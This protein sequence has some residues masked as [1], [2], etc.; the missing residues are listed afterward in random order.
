MLTARAASLRLLLALLGF[1]IMAAGVVLAIEWQRGSARAIAEATRTLEDRA[2]DVA[3]HIQRDVL[4]RLRAVRAWV[5]L[6]VAQELAVDDVDKR[7]SATL[8]ELARDLGASDLAVALDS[9]G[10]IVS[11]SDSSLI[12]RQAATLLP[13]LD[14]LRSSSVMRDARGAGWFAIE[15]PV[16]RHD[17]QMIGRIAILA[18]WDRVVASGLAEATVASLR[19]DGPDG[20]LFRGPEAGTGTDA[21]EENFVIGRA[22]RSP[23]PGLALTVSVV[24]PRQEVLAPVRDARRTALLAAAAVLLVLVPAALML[25]R[26]ASRTLARQEALATMGTMAAGLAHEIRTPLG[27]MR[28]SLD[29]LER[30]ADDARR[31][32]LATIVREENVRLERLVDD[33]LAFARPRAPEVSEED[34][35]ALVRATGPMLE[36]V[37]ARHGARLVLALEPARASVDSD[38]IRQV[39]LNLVDN[40]ARAAGAGGTVTVES[41]SGRG[42]TLLEVRDTG[43]GIPKK[44]R[45]TL[46]DP[47]VTTRSTGTGLGLAIVRR[48]IEAHGGRIALVAGAPAGAA[49]GAGAH[50]RITFPSP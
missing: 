26:S 19:I 12:G 31:R 15:L 44:I 46:W 28:T 13:G 48:I 42:E 20:A 3:E 36:A 18:P 4:E 16:V 50:F 5:A 49:T 1:G 41:H 34:I 38:Q 29:L 8:R 33:L 35:D 14:T 24:A 23:V 17:G 27:V 6:D 2:D 30:G 21:D 37:C 25:A 9:T 11:A 47:F 45:D 39:L 22:E 40:G 10:R 43:S 32:E 7:L